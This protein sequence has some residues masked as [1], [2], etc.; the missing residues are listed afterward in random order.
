[1]L[2]QDFSLICDDRNGPSEFHV[3]GS[4]KDWNITSRLSRIQ[5]PTLLI[6]GRFDEAQDVTME[7]YFREISGKVKWV[8]FAES[9]HCPHLEE[10]DAFIDAVGRFLAA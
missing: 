2:T 7:P 10:T 8:R 5:V 3:L 1:M 9:S 4:L 6:N